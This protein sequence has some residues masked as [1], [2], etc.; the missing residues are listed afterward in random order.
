MRLEMV[1]SEYSAA[2]KPVMP[3]IST[4]SAD[5]RSVARVMPYGAGQA[6]AARTWMPSFHTTTSNTTAAMSCPAVP[7]T[8]MARCARRDGHASSDTEP[9]TMGIRNGRATSR[10]TAQRP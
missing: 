3:V 9:A 5:S 10:L 6:P 2:A 4:I 8:A 1:G 7:T